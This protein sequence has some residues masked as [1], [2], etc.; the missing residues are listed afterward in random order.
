ML[1][2]LFKKPIGLKDDLYDIAKRKY[3]QANISKEYFNNNLMKNKLEIIQSYLSTA[4]ECINEE[5]LKLNHSPASPFF[6]YFPSTKRENCRVKIVSCS[7]PGQ[8]KL[9]YDYDDDI[10]L[11]S[12]IHINFKI[13]FF[14][15]FTYIGD[16]AI[17]ELFKTYIQSLNLNN[18]FKNIIDDQLTQIIDALNK[19]DNPL[20][21]INISTSTTPTP[22]NWS[23]FSNPHLLEYRNDNNSN[24]N[25]GTHLMPP[26]PSAP[27]TPPP[28]HIAPV[29]PHPFSG[30][31]LS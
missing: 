7:Q 10:G 6:F 9:E 28:S 13:I 14:I 23:H 30:G 19:N 24:S 12:S 27:S 15:I 5:Y 18:A 4:I 25:T 16:K 17:Y 20:N 11:I 22:H 2:M 21:P 8:P 1:R 31:F 29:P 3:G 26:L